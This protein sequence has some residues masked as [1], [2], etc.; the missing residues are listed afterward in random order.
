MKR[1]LLLNNVPAP[2]FDPLFEKLGEHPGWHLTVCYSSD[3]NEAVGWLGKSEAGRS[4]HDTVVLD[5]S[6]PA[7]KSRLGSPA[8]A[9]AVLMKLLMRD[10]PDYLICYG[11]TLMPQTTALLWSVATGTPFALIGDANYYCDATSGLKKPVKRFWLRSLARR[12][13]ALIAIGTANRLFWE[14]YG[15]KAENIFDARFAVD[16]AAYSRA[17]AG[18]EAEAAGLKS[19]LGLENKVVFLFVGRLVRRKNADLI[20]RAAR[21]LNDDRVAVLIAGSGEERASL[22]ALAGGDRRIVFA[23]NVPPGELPLYYAASDV[24]VLPAAQEP[25]GLVINEAMACGLAIIAHRHCGAAIDLVA[26]D[27]GVTLETFS[28]LELARAMES[29]ANDPPLLRSM[30]ARSREKIEAWSIDAEA[31]GIIRAV[32]QSGKRSALRG[33]AS[34]LEDMK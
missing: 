21:M 28:E 5:A 25:W 1:V 19:K 16:N 18:G 11:Y 17:L 9:A 6:W 33:T 8:A 32:N 14:S 10:K 34:D 3:W 13:A 26:P 2:Y 31:D 29:V 12:A 23:G 27:N 30:Q 7:L 24:L 4:S 15:A 20:I 22:E